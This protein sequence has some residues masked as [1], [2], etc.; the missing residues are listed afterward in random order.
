MLYD[1]NILWTPTTRP[2]DLEATLR[3]SA[4]LGYSVVA[5]NHIITPPLRGPTIANPI[6]L[7][8]YTTS[9]TPP[10]LPRLLRRATL[11]LSDPSATHRLAELSRAYDLLAVRPTTEKAFL[12]ACTSLPEAAL[13]SLDLTAPF[14]FHFRPKPVMAAVRR[15]LR[16]E[17]CYA[18]A[19]AGA[20]GPERQHRAALFVGNLRGL[21]RAA[22]AG[23]RGLVVSSGGAGAAQLRAP[24]DVANLLAVWGVDAARAAEAL[25]AVP[26]AVVV[27]EGL[28][29]R[30]GRGVVDVLRGAAAG[31][32]E[33]GEGGRGGRG[34]KGPGEGG[35]EGK[36]KGVK[37]KAG[38]GGPGEEVP[39]SKKLAKKLRKAQLREQQAG[40]AAGD[41][42]S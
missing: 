33:E 23:G 29:R 7:P 3:T 37:R 32:E 9:T 1:L 11:L 35:G 6:P 38:D 41:E 15:G 30:G 22:G 20:P 36:K 10:K 2:A 42:A 31:E 28:K 14:P 40:A 26:R 18:Q 24:P 16:F 5:L 19:L 25:E 12:A 27:N 39:V 13:I 8:P 34:D 17:V 21:A 4:A